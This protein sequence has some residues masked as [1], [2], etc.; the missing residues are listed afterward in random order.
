MMIATTGVRKGISLVLLLGLMSA[1]TVRAWHNPAL[2]HH[3]ICQAENDLHLHQGDQGCCLCDF[4]FSPPIPVESTCFTDS[5]TTSESATL[6]CWV[7]VLPDNICIGYA[8]RGP[9]ASV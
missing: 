6:Y 8:L 7:D 9:P 1:Y 3:P 5:R 2:H 4:I